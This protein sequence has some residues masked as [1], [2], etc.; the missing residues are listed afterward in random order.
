MPGMLKLDSRLTLV[1]RTPT[2]IQLGLPRAVVQCEVTP[3]QEYLLTALRSGTTAQTLR[4]LGVMHGMD[5]SAVDS[6]VNVM[7]PA[8]EVA[9]PPRLRIGIDG[10]G[11]MADWIGFLLRPAHEVFGVAP[12][13]HDNNL[14]LVIIVAPFAV[15]PTRAGAWLRREIAHMAV[16]VGDS[17]VEVSQIVRAGET[18]CLVCNGFNRADADSAW[19]GMVTQAQA[20][21][22]GGEDV[23]TCVEVGL[24]VTRIVEEL[25][26]EPVESGTGSTDFDKSYQRGIETFDISTGDWSSV[27]ALPADRC[28]CRAQPETEM[29]HAA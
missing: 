15:T 24:R 18:A 1:W 6:F 28:S 2:S 8:F 14:D 4:A 29:A 27:P 26:V 19:V 20:K 7:A 22:A 13:A 25:L 21:P 5:A 17:C 16:V 23:L 3:A 10:R 9:R 12:G 11:A